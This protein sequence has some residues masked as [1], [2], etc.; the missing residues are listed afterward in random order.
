[1]RTILS[2]IPDPNDILLS[3]DLLKVTQAKKGLILITGP[4][5]SGKSTTMAAMLEYINTH[6]HRHVITL[7]D[8][9][10]FVY[11]DKQS[12]FNQRELGRH[13]DSF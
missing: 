8:P 10:E 13:F 11:K 12:F 2:D 4:T 3:E 1:M 5:G 9:V 7:E 6:L